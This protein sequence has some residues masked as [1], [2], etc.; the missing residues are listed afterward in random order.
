MKERSTE[1]KDDREW[2][3]G[4]GEETVNMANRE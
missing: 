4:S 1:N 3:K 2:E